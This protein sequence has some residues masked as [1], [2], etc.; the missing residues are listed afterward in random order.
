MSCTEVSVRLGVVVE[1]GLL[2]FV[3]LRSRMVNPLV[4]PNPSC[5]M[6]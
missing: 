6:V 1:C 3:A 4:I 2:I 5:W